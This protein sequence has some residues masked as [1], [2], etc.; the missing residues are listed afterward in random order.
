M[1][2]IGQGSSRC[3]GV[4]GEGRDV[5]WQVTKSQSS[6]DVLSCNQLQLSACGSS[7]TSQQLRSQA[8]LLYQVA[9]VSED[10]ATIFFVLFCFHSLGMTSNMSG[11]L[12]DFAY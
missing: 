5:Q 10:L 9:Q 8:V 7:V 4:F 2:A 3:T 11:I 12:N 6:L 1:G